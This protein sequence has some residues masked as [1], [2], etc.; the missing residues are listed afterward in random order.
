MFTQNGGTD[1]VSRTY[2]ETNFIF[3]GLRALHLVEYIKH[4]EISGTDKILKCMICSRELHN[5]RIILHFAVTHKDEYTTITT[6]AKRWGLISSTD[7]CKEEELLL[8]TSVS[9]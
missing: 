1:P 9:S 7:T 4:P 2:R 6:L 3:S 8:I 5:K